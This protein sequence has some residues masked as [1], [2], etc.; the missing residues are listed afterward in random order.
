MS[1]NCSQF[2]FMSVQLWSI[3]SPNW[4]IL[5]QK[6]L[7]TKPKLHELAGDFVLINVKQYEDFKLDQVAFSW[8]RYSLKC[9]NMDSD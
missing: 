8:Y 1:H 6:W 7:E 3:F 5:V 9:E 2:E 4:H